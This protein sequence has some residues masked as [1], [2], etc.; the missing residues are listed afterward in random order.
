MLTTYV[1]R[2][3]EV[4]LTTLGATLGVTL[5][6]AETEPVPTLFAADTTQL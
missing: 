2:L 3:T 1:I 4:R 5:V 6:G